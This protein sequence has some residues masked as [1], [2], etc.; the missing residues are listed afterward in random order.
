MREPTATITFYGGAGEVTGA[1][2][3]FTYTAADG[4]ATRILFDCGLIQGSVVYEERNGEPFAYDASKVDALFVSH[5][6]IDHS[7]RVPKLVHEGFRGPIYSTPPTRAIAELMV[8][9]SRG[10]MMKES[11]RRAAPVLYDET[12]IGHTMGQW[13][14]LEYGESVSV[15]PLSVRLLR[16]GHVL[17]SAMIEVSFPA[18]GGTIRRLVYTGDLGDPHNLLLEDTEPILNTDY[19]IMESVYG[20]RTHEGRDVRAHR[21][22]DVIE[23]TVKMRGTLMIPAFSVEKTQELLFEMNEMVEH[24]RIPSVPIYLDS[25]LAIKVTRVYGR[26]KNYFNKEVRDIIASGDDIFTFARLEQTLSTEES[27]AINDEPPPKIIIAG[28]GM[29]NGGRIVHHE[30]RHLPDPKSTLLFTGYQAPGSMGRRIQDG[31]REV[32]I[33]G[34]RVPIRARVVSIRG[35]SAHRDSDNLVSFVRGTV[36]TVRTVFVALGEPASARF[37]AQRIRDYLGARAVV[38]ERG[39]EIVLN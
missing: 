5:G 38:P 21:L 19:L 25:P 39:E 11:K 23:D 27:K 20:D 26:F 18:A 29:S 30:K 13:K 12:D 14:T 32:I 7:G 1:N 36:D 28:S 22:E 4:A 8:V 31:A 15:G 17:G 9:D 35:Y 33:H 2:I 34:E 10:V 37:L 3:L 24:G 16:A 6:H